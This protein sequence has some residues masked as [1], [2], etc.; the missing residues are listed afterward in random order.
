MSTAHQVAA[1]VVVKSVYMLRIALALILSLVFATN[2]SAA[3]QLD[4][5]TQLRSA[6]SASAPVTETAPAR[7]AS[8]RAIAY[9]V[10][11]RNS[12]W[13]R[14]SYRVGGWVRATA[15]SPLKAP[16][17]PRISC[18][19]SR[20]L[21]SESNGGLRDGVLM[22][23]EGASFFTWSFRR[24][25]RFND[26]RVRWGSCRLVKMIT[27][28]LGAYH[29]AHPAAARVAVGDLSRRF[30]GPLDGHATHQRGVDVDIYYPRRDGREMEPKTV[31]QVDRR[32][33]QDL[34]NR[35]TRAGASKIFVGLNV[36][37]HG[38]AGVVSRIGHH[39]DH[40]HIRIPG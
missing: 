22:P 4:Q 3:V 16:V 26:A 25:A 14:I 36:G 7:N 21:G 37:L 28:V 24:Q 13:L 33:A 15:T 5:S 40:L 2:A 10:V 19:R 1:S 8:G 34:V 6:P 29:R 27:R 17:D 23:V 9:N 32:L 31:A 20:S 30:G 35:F 18:S 39:D 11:G 12:G 38:K